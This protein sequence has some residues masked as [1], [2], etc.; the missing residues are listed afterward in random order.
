MPTIM[1]GIEYD[2]FGTGPVRVQLHAV[3]YRLQSDFDACWFWFLTSGLSND[4]S[5][6]P[7]EFG[8]AYNIRV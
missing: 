8:S 5:A 7:S 2:R 4:A 3:Q 6:L 1:S